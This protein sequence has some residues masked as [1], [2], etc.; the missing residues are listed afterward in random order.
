MFSSRNKKN[1]VYPCIPEFYYIKVG[2]KEIKIIKVR[3]HDDFARLSPEVI[4][5]FARSIQPSMNPAN[6]SEITYKCKFFI[7]KHG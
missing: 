3:F 5:L 4:K 6:K 7:A 2:F 1:T